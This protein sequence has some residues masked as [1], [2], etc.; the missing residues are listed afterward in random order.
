MTELHYKVV[1]LL[2]PTL[3]CH[4]VIVDELLIKPHFSLSHSSYIVI[5]RTGHPTQNALHKY[6]VLCS[7]PKATAVQTVT[8]MNPFR[9]R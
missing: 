1:T 8:I 3:N 7:L 9:E 5:H 4:S 2:T 6:L